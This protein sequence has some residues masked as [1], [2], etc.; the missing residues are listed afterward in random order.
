MTQVKN[1]ARTAG[2][3]ASSLRRSRPFISIVATVSQRLTTLCCGGAGI[4]IIV[5]AL[6][7]H[8][9]DPDTA[10]L[11]KENF[12]NSIDLLIET[13]QVTDRIL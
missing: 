13:L 5:V 2:G 1:F 7:S 6:C 4:G 3:Y 9:L 12:G 11:A 10:A 8:H